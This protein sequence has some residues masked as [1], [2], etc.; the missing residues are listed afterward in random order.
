[1]VCR[2]DAVYDPFQ[3][4]PGKPH[5][6]SG[7]LRQFQSSPGPRGPG[8]WSA[9]RAQVKVIEFQSSPGPRGPGVAGR[10][11]APR[12]RS[13]SFNPRPALAGRASSQQITRPVT[14]ATFQSS[15]GPRGPGVTITVAPAED[16]FVV[17]I[18]ARP[19]R[20]G[21]RCAAASP[22]RS[23]WRFNPRP[24]LAGRASLDARGNGQYLAEFQSSPGPRGPGV[25]TPWR[26]RRNP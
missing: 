7:T 16:G 11:I 25:N 10:R 13:S 4:S 9:D 1:M 18:L 23:S 14:G 19:S 20:A 6:V 12:L 2:A 21:R 8:V 3:S 5:V 22:S 15:P 24:A 26:T 17:S